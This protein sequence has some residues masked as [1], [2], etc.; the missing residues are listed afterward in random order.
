MGC[1]GSQVDVVVTSTGTNHYAEV[2]GGFEHLGIDFVG[3]DDHTLDISHSIEKLLLLGIFLEFYH[4][5]ASTGDNLFHRL[6]CCS[7]KGLFGCNKNLH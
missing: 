5:D 3:T 1:S 7:S 4:F 2:L 6:Y